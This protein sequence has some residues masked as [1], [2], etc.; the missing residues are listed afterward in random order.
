MKIDDVKA[1][2]LRFLKRIEEYEQRTEKETKGYHKEWY[3]KYGI[4]GTKES[5]ALKRASLD[6]SRE[7]VKLRK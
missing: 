1:E 7:L 4:K 6:L 5:G 3:A 2:C